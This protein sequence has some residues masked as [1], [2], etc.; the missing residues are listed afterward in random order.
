MK[1]IVGILMFFSVLSGMVSCAAR[2]PSVHELTPHQHKYPFTE[3]IGDYH[4]RLVVDHVE[5]EMFFLFVDISESLI[6]LV[7]LERI[8]GQVLLPDGTIKEENFRPT[9]LS[10]HKHIRKKHLQRRS[11]LAGIYIVQ[12]D[13]LKTSPKFELQVSVPFEG[14]KYELTFHYEMPS[15]SKPSN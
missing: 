6:K 9:R 13:W 2:Q 3:V 11:R 10:S 8:R 14:R 7:R 4:L 5:G 15:I 1:R 12:A